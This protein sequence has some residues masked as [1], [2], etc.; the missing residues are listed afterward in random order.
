MIKLGLLPWVGHMVPT[1][2]RLYAEKVLV[3]I[4]KGKNHLENVDLD[5]MAIQKWTINIIRRFGH[6]SCSSGRGSVR[7]FSEHSIECL[8]CW[9]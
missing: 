9:E 8:K 7:S 6:N 1:G 5:S 2:L 4:T 3:Q